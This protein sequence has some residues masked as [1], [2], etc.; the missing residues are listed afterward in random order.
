VSVVHWDDVPAATPAEGDIAPTWRRLGVAA[1]TRGVGVRLASVPPGHRSSAIHTHGAEEEIFYLLGGSGLLWQAGETCAVAAGDCI[2]HRAGGPAHVLRAGDDGLEF[3]V[4]GTRRP[5]ELVHLPRTGRAFAGPT[6]VPAEG[7]VNLW[8]IDAAAGAPEFPPPGARP[9]NVVATA[10]VP[11]RDRIGGADVRA[12]VARLGSA[13]D[14]IQTGLNLVAVAAESLSAPPHCH[15]AEE[16]VFVVTDG[17]GVCLLGDHT[18]AVRR[19]SVVARPPGTGVAHAFRAG[20]RGMSLLAYGTREPADIAYYPRSNKLSF[21][22][23]GVIGRI[24]RLDYWDG[25]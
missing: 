19:G 3:L 13:A 5:V 12:S 8:A 7:D 18:H 21:R 24:E 4:Y 15:S 20:P 17:E 22:G 6:V 16:E 14:S 1:G 9:A 25:E 2:V 23:L 11:R 10:D